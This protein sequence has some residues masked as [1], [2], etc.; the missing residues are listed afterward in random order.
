M[1]S[2]PL[3]S[4]LRTRKGCRS[5]CRA[6]PRPALSASRVA[7]YIPKGGDSWIALIARVQ[8]SPITGNSANQPAADS[9][10]TVVANGM[11]YTY[12]FGTK[13]PAGFNDCRPFA[14]AF[15]HP[16]T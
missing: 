15:T 2:S 11:G 5:T 16:A 7:S 6:S 12:T 1:E 13:A 14:L 8:T 10:G 3:I 4:P 9:G